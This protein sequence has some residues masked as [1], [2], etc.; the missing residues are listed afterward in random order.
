MNK[1]GVIISGYEDNANIF[2]N[3]FTHVGLDMASKININN[4]VKE[5]QSNSM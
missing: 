5:K 1:H 4:Y 3:C 2:N